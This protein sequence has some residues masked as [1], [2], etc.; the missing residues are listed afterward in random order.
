MRKLICFLSFCILGGFSTFSQISQPPPD[1]C[2]EGFVDQIFLDSWGEI[3]TLA[4]SGDVLFFCEQADFFKCLLGNGSID[5]LY[6]SLRLASNGWR[7]SDFILVAYYDGYDLIEI[8]PILI[9]IACGITLKDLSH[10]YRG[11]PP[12]SMVVMTLVQTK[13]VPLEFSSA[14]PS[15][16]VECA[17]DLP[18]TCEEYLSDNSIVDLIALNSC[19]GDEYDVSVPS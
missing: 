9:L 12:H 18:A 10:L 17:E 13:I 7:C 14:L 15:Y 8:F 11:Q 3:I 4:S 19:T 1:P 5:L 16:T 6:H 2:D